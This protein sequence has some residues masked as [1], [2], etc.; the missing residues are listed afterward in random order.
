MFPVFVIFALIL[1]VDCKWPIDVKATIDS[2]FP[3]NGNIGV[4]L[5]S[6]AL[7][8]CEAQN[9]NDTMVL[10]IQELVQV[11]LVHV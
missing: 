10:C 4:N 9:V 11:F 6:D 2:Y 3:V 1:S 5:Y 7:L 8:T